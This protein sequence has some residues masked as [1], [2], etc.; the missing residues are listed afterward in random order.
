MRTVCIPIKNRPVITYIKIEIAI[1]KLKISAKNIIFFYSNKKRGDFSWQNVHCFVCLFYLL[2]KGQC[3]KIRDWVCSLETFIYK[4]NV[5]KTSF[6]LIYI[7]LCC[8]LLILW[9][10]SSAVQVPESCLCSK[11]RHRILDSSGWAPEDN[12]ANR[13]CVISCSL[14]FPNSNWSASYS[15]KKGFLN[16]SIINANHLTSELLY[17]GK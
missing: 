1:H 12:A 14:F 6:L 7:S 9:L 8:Y 5:F 11:L 3:S 15:K 10:K 4:P 2:Q 17:R 16:H 13:Y